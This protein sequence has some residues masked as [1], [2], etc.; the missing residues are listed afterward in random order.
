MFFHNLDFDKESLSAMLIIIINNLKQLTITFALLTYYLICV[1][2]K[3][4]KIHKFWDHI[5]KQ[6]SF[7][8]GLI[9]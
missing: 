9:E 5:Y 6:T 7:K 3:H 1:M 4:I 2:L 8:N